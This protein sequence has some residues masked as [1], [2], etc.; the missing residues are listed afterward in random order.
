M[1]EGV[2]TPS[3]KKLEEWFWSVVGNTELTFRTMGH[4]FPTCR[5]LMPTWQKSASLLAAAVPWEK[6][7]GCA[8]QHRSLFHWWLFIT[9]LNVPSHEWSWGLGIVQSPTHM[10]SWDS[11]CIWS[12]ALPTLGR[13]TRKSGHI[14]FHLGY[15]ISEGL[16]W[17]NPLLQ[18]QTVLFLWDL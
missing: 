4:I 5:K 16:I 1:I 15:M 8:F 17:T 13:A 3:T 9:I 6:R 10:S 11:H 12:A 18:P 2:K 7:P 14:C